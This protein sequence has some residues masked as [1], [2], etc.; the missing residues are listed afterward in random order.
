MGIKTAS[1]S[2]VA[3]AVAAATGSTCCQGTCSGMRQWK[4]WGLMT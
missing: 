3:L 4:A 2:A 1:I